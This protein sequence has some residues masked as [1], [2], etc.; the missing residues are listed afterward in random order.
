MKDQVGAGFPDEMFHSPEIGF[1]HVTSLLN[2][3]TGSIN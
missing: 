3:S 1:Q 2:T